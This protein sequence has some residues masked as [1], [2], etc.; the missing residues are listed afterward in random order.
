MANYLLKP[1]VDH[2]D[3]GKPPSRNPLVNFQRGFEARFERFREVYR[4]PLTM[5]LAR[6]AVFIPAFMAFVLASFLLAPFLGRNFFPSVDSGQILMHARAPI[7]TRVE[8][9]PTTWPTSRRRSA[10]SSRRARS[11]PWPTMSA[12]R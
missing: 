2:G 5:A 1:H 11:R 9:T 10:R 7:G 3:G 8:E 12:C 4:D 6:R